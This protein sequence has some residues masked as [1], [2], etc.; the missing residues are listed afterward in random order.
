MPI[1][2]DFIYSLSFHKWSCSFV[3]WVFVWAIAQ[4]T[5]ER[6]TFSHKFRHTKQKQK[7]PLKYKNPKTSI[8]NKNKKKKEKD[9]KYIS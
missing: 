3:A 9:T 6:I 5:K 4:H 1:G 8:E 7:E 2:V